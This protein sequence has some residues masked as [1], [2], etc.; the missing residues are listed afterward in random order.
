MED[1]VEDYCDLVREIF[2]FGPPVVVALPG[3]A[4]AGGL[5]VAAAAD[6]RIAAK[7]PG[8]YGLSEVLLGVPVPHCLL[9]IFRHVMGARGMERLAATGEN[10]SVERAP[11]PGA[12][13][14]SRAGRGP[15]LLGRRARAVE[16]CQAALGRR[17]RRSSGARARRRWPV[18][19]GPA[20]GD[21][22]LDFWFGKRRAATHSRAG[23]EALEEGLVH[24][25]SRRSSRTS[26]CR[27]PS[28]G[29]GFSKALQPLSRARAVRDRLEDPAATPRWSDPRH[30]AAQARDLLAGTSRGGA[31]G[32]CFARVAAFD[33]LLGDLGFSPGRPRAAWARTSI[34]RRSSS[35]GRAARGSATSA[36]RCRAVV[37]AAA[38]RMRRPAGRSSLSTRRRGAFESA[39]A[40]AVPGGTACDRD[41]G[42]S[43]D[44]DEFEREWQATFRNGRAFPVGRLAA[45]RNGR[46]ERSLSREERC[47][48]TT[49]IRG[50]ACRC[51]GPR[52]LPLAE[53][54]RSRGGPARRR[55][56]HRRRSGSGVMPQSVLPAYLETGPAA[57][58]A[59]RAIA[60]ARGLP[61]TAEGVAETSTSEE[62]TPGGLSPEARGAGAA[63]SRSTRLE[64]DVARRRRGAAPSRSRRGRAPVRDELPG[65]EREGRSVA[66]PGSALSGLAAQDLLR[67][68]AL[69]GR[70][71]GSLAVDLSPG[72]VAC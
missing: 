43:V 63:R 67:N 36:F 8:L 2:V 56:R 35:S 22:F 33:A 55:V 25:R 7:G 27:A 26:T 71:A 18:S 60:I 49:G 44:E 50:C 69:R 62:S 52:G 65:R 39:F 14:P 24:S 29:S 10:I 54:F 61:G 45:A 17:T 28:R 57:D 41:F 59:F 11:R 23:G 1:F 66:H 15:A 12:H 68:D 70:L 40:D 48:S 72:H 38:G 19:T 32:T 47:G 51:V 64:E 9:E 13:G 58:G 46:V 34:T 16:L 42:A 37:P 4:I 6:E 30:E 20:S 5:I 21:P 3:H 53:I 31:G